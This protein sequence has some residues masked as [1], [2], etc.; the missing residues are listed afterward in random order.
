MKKGNS[1]PGLMFPSAGGRKGAGLFPE[2]LLCSNGRW[3]VKDSLL[4]ALMSREPSEL[5]RTGGPPREREDLA[6]L[7]KQ[8]ASQIE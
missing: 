3:G 2:H 1:F 6:V 7:S 5:L 4:C 8:Y